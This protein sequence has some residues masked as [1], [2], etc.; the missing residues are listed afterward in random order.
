MV[1]A[2]EREL[3]AAGVTEKPRVVVA[4]A[5]YWHH[6][7]MDH[8]AGRGLTVLIPPD[9]NKRRARGRA[10]TAAVMRSCAACWRPTRQAALRQAPG[11]DRAGV[12]EHQVQPPDRSVPTRGRPACRSEWRLSTAT[13]NL[14]KLHKHTTAAL[15]V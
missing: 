9:A 14:L 15:A 10:G 8:L 6:D 5:G 3:T 7:Q 12:R 11:D 1:S 13:H 2:A 4:D